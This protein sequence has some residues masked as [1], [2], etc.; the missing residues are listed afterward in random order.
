MPS[1]APA[2]IAVL[3]K[4][5]RWAPEL[6]RQLLDRAIPVRACRSIRDLAEHVRNC[7]REQGRAVA[8]LDFDFSPGEVLYLVCALRN[9][10]ASSV[11]IGE[12]G[13]R[14]LEPSLRELGVTAFHT[15]PLAGQRLA[16][17]CVKL[18]QTM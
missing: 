15:L 13:C 12:P 14:A 18:L 7:L 4:R 11:V 9:A 3:E 5:P 6:Q 2:L 8:V 17:E 1:P 16:Q 10:G